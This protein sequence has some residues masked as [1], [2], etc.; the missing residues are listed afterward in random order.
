M[1]L[2]SGGARNFHLGAIAQGSGNGSPP[3]ESSNKITVRDRRDYVPQK[4]DQSADIVYTY[5]DCRNDQNLKS[6]HNS[7]PDS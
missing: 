4:L 6:S 5:F 2:G 3:V 7:P 1:P